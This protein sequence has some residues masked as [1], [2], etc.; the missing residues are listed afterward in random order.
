MIDLSHVIENF[1]RSEI[2]YDWLGNLEISEYDISDKNKIVERLSSMYTEEELLL[3]LPKVLKMN[4]RTDNDKYKNCVIENGNNSYMV[5]NPWG[6]RVYTG[7]LH[8]KSAK[9]FMLPIKNWVLPWT[10]EVQI[11]RPQDSSGKAVSSSSD[12]N[13]SEV[14]LK[15]TGEKY[16]SVGKNLYV[17]AKDIMSVDN[18]IIPM[19]VRAN[20]QIIN[21]RL[22]H[23][24]NM[25]NNVNKN[26]IS[27]YNVYDSKSI[28]PS[29]EITADLNSL[30]KSDK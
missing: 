28:L 30:I 17:K 19:L 23:N 26:N 11:I 16:M 15:K 8:K 6:W 3:L 25:V 1:Q 12:A 7:H 13:K 5:V 9:F 29:I 10:K 24:M 14:T 4:D 18:T 2:S 22:V 27:E 21:D 20:D